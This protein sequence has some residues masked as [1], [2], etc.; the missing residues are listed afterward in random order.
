MI[1]VRYG[2]FETNSSSTHAMI[3]AADPPKNVPPFVHFTIGEFGWEHNILN[4]IAEKAAYLYTSA[5][6]L[7][8]DEEKVND[9]LAANLAIYGVSCWFDKPK[10]YAEDKY[11][12][13]DNGYVDHCG[14]DQHEEWVRRM[15]TDPEALVRFLFNDDSYVMTS[16]DNCDD[17]EYEWQKEMENP[18]YRCEVYYKGN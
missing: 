12:W 17:E 11:K 3:V 14:Q 1:K 2:E 4:T 18:A 9:A 8:K 16:N 15:L 5:L 6:V 7:S 10:W 13:L